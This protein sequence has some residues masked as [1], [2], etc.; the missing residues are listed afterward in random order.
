M[1]AGI[2]VLFIC[3]SS[4]SCHIT[5]AQKLLIEWMS[6]HLDQNAT[7]YF[8]CITNSLWKE[9][10]NIALFIS[11]FLEIFLLIH[12]KITWKR[13]LDP[14]GVIPLPSSNFVELLSCP[15]LTSAWDLTNNFSLFFK[16]HTL[17]LLKQNKWLKSKFE[18]PKAP[19]T[20]GIEKVYFFFRA[21]SSI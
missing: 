16:L 20:N 9:D 19:D 4:S 11:L 21:S 15:S 18:D 10:N 3:Y 14:C 6:N 5:G 2:F 12:L 8:V 13:D 17:I 7:I 1:K